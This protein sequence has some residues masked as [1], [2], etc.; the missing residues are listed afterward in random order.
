MVRHRYEV[1][2]GG[3]FIILSSSQHIKGRQTLETADRQSL[4]PREIG[5]N[6]TARGFSLP[7]LD[8]C[9]TILVWVFFLSSLKALKKWTIVFESVSAFHKNVKRETQ[10]FFSCERCNASASGN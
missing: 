8:L 2:D 5:K 6:F 7:E 3:I 4:L 9:S 1:V 10:R